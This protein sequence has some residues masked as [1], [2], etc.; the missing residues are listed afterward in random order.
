MAFAA[1]REWF[2]PRDGQW[3]GVLQS[4]PLPAIAIRLDPDSGVIFV[5]SF[6][7]APPEGEIYRLWL[8]VPGRP[9]LLL[10]AF[11]AGVSG[12]APALAGLG[13]S[14]LGSAEVVVT[15]EPKLG[16]AAAAEGDPPGKVVY[17]GR[18]APE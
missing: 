5:R 6:A 11:T 14:R 8:L 15:Q 9:A 1:Y 16:A 18:L 7:P 10:G 13:R 3:V 2:W 17:R 12:R 4:E